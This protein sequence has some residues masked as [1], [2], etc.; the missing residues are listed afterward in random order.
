MPADTQPRASILWRKPSQV[1][2][3]G[4]YL[5]ANFSAGQTYPI[6]DAVHKGRALQGLVN[7]RTDDDVCTFT[8]SWGF[9]HVRLEGGRT[10]RFPLALFHLHRQ[11]FL[12]L[13]RLSTALRFKTGKDSQG[14]AKIGAALLALKTSRA[15]RDAYVFRRQREEAMDTWL[16]EPEQVLADEGVPASELVQA[17]SENRRIGLTEFAARTL[18]SQLSVET[19]L[20]PV[21]KGGRW[22]FEERP[23]VRSLEQ[24]LRWTV[25]SR[26]RVLHHF[27]CDACGREAISGRSD[28]RF[29][30]P[31]C[32]T[33]DRVARFR[34]RE[35]DAASARAVS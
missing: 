25:P 32:G 29:C 16:T 5:V 3:D 1:T 28:A 7:A 13:T 6:L 31:E 33:R 12:A 9:L 2:L 26:Y 14:G 30:T 15:Q 20:R 22:A 17:R 21:R 34:Q 19:H 10:D 27:F 23:I 35:A 4:D 18:A 8:K 11:Y 24:V